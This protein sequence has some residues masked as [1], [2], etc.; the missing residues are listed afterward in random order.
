MLQPIL[1]FKNLYNLSAWYSVAKYIVT[2]RLV[3]FRTATIWNL[4]R[5][6]TLLPLPQ[7]VQLPMV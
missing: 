3:Q 6:Y 2:H 4:V 7:I 5:E 1:V